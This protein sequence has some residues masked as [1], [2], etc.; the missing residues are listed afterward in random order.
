[1]LKD[2][3]MSP[4][5]RSFWNKNYFELKNNWERVGIEKALYIL[6]YCLKVDYKF[7]FFK[8]LT[9]P[10]ARKSMTL[11]H[12]KHTYLQD[13][14]KL[15]LHNKFMKITLIF[16]TSPVYLPSLSF[17]PQEARSPFLLS[18]HFSIIY[19]SLLGWSISPRS[20][21]FLGSLLLFYEGFHVH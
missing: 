13:C 10:K 15:D 4:R 8:A 9:L 2:Q 3:S 21:H 16:F 19:C 1:M 11:N 5:N 18:C 20:N 6:L 7:P 14:T 12:W 17:P